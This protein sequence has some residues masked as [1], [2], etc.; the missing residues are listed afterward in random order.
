MAGAATFQVGHGRR[1]CARSTFGVL[2]AGERRG[3]LDAKAASIEASTPF[4]LVAAAA[5]SGA[6][7]AQAVG[8]LLVE[9][10]FARTRE[11][12]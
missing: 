9:H 4:A 7:Q 5:D 6:A 2:H 10:R 11:I 1:S 3:Q 8:V 12:D